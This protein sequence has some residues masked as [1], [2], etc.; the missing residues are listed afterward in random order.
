MKAETKNVK[1]SLV[2]HSEV[3]DEGRGCTCRFTVSI[4]PHQLD[5][6]KTESKLHVV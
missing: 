3:Q 1:L 6:P 5:H 2:G 4:Q